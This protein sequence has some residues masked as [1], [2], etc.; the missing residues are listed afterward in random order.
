MHCHGRTHVQ[1]AAQGN[2]RELARGDAR[3]QEESQ[4]VQIRLVRLDCFGVCYPA[5]HNISHDLGLVLASK[6]VSQ[7]WLGRLP[8]WCTVEH[9]P[10]LLCAGEVQDHGLLPHLNTIFVKFRPQTPIHPQPVTKIYAILFLLD[11]H[12]L[13]HSVHALYHSHLGSKLYS[14]LFLEEFSLLQHPT[15]LRISEPILLIMAQAEATCITT[16]TLI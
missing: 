2:R 12:G 13:N 7:T 16:S 3:Q 11:F 14:S 8:S 4:L 9:Q 1:E 15:R 10:V 6:I 5:W